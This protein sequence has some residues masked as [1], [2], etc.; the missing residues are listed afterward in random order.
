APKLDD[1]LGA[2]FVEP[3]SD[4]EQ[5][6]AKIWCEVLGLERVGVTSNFFEL[7]G[8]SLLAT[9]AVSRI[10]EE[11]KVELPVKSLFTT[12]TIAELCQALA[13]AGA[14]SPL[15]PPPVQRISRDDDM[16]LSF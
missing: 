13:T 7:G 11:F 14:L 6:M 3:R 5:R 4:D 8:H 1:L 9:Q 12:P 10:R 16:P 15:A 2:D